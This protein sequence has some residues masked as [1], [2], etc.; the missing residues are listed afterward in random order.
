MSQTAPKGA[1]SVLLHKIKYHK[2]AGT[3]MYKCLVGI[4]IPLPYENINSIN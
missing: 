1:F 3:K 4:I 2:V